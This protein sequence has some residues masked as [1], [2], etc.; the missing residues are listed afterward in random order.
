MLI[1]DQVWAMLTCKK[2]DQKE[3][4]AANNKAVSFPDWGDFSPFELFDVVA[5]PGSGR[6]PTIT[7]ATCCGCGARAVIE[8]QYGFDRPE[9]F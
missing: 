1:K 2:C 7:S 4:H 6:E 9:G 3:S 5:S 8:T